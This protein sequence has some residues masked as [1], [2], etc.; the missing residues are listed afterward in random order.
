MAGTVSPGHVQCANP[1][2]RSLETQAGFHE[3]TCLRCGRLTRLTD[4]TLV[5]EEEQYSPIGL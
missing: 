4:G 5:P 1:E 3:V 2:C